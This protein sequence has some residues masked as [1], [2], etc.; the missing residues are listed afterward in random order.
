MSSE[1]YEDRQLARDREYARAWEK[2][3]PAQRRQ[4]A[5]SGIKG[6]ELPVYRTGK[7]DEEAILQRASTPESA[8]V[9]ADAGSA[10][11]NDAAT[12]LRRIMAEL[13]ASSR[14]LDLECV[15]L[16][17]RL[18]YDGSSMTDIAKRH[19]VTRAAVSKK[20][21]RY[22]ELL[23]TGTAPGQRKLTARKAYARRAHRVHNRNV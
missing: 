4:L 20:V 22:A 18:D 13:L 2:L 10:T 1:R 12:A 21:A 17:L 7:H 16:V 14:T 23:R 15:S 3:T 11:V 19:G 8:P 9:E 6:P 5:K